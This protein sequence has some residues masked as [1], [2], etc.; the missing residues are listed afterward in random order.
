MDDPYLFNANNERLEAFKRIIIVLL[1]VLFCA[2]KEASL[3]TRENDN[4]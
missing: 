2:R 3:N 4:F 1:N